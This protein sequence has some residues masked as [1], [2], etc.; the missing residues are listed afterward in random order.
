MGR[1]SPALSLINCDKINCNTFLNTNGNLLA[2]NTLWVAVADIITKWF[3]CKQCCAQLPW[4]SCALKGNKH[5][6]IDIISY[7][8]VYYELKRGLFRVKKIRRWLHFV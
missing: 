5:S 7:T 6:E 3:S 8:V 4:K 1:E 2:I